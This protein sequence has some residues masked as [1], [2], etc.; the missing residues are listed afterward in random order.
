MPELESRLHLALADRYRIERE[1][2][3]VAN[4]TSVLRARMAGGVS[5]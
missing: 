5:R 2:I 3:V 1:L 4:W